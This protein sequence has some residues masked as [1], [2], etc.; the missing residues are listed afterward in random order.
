MRLGYHKKDAHEED[1]RQDGNNK[2]SLLVLFHCA[3]GNRCRVSNPGILKKNKKYYTWALEGSR[4]CAKSRSREK[5]EAVFAIN[6]ETAS[7]RRRAASQRECICINMF[8]HKYSCTVVTHAPSQ[9]TEV[10]PTAPP[11]SPIMQKNMA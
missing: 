1:K 2:P 11:S 5:R 9:L 3:A 7:Q 4:V 8:S 6:N 10:L